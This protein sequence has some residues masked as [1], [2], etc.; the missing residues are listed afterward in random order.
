MKCYLICNELDPQGRNWRYSSWGDHD[1]QHT[2][3]TTAV[4]LQF[5]EIEVAAQGFPPR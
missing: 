5:D 2:G 3:H 4:L 1:N